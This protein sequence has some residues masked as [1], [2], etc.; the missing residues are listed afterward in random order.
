MKSIQTVASSITT[1]NEGRCQEVSKEND[2]PFVKTINYL[3]TIPLQNI[4]SETTTTTFCLDIRR[5]NPKLISNMY[6]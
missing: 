2:G 5:T 3:H 4:Y 6:V 1:Q